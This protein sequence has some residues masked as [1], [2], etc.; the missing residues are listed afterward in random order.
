MSHF[1]NFKRIH[2][3]GFSCKKIVKEKLLYY[4]D[5]LPKSLIELWENEGWCGYAKGFIWVVDPADYVDILNKWLKTSSKPFFAF[6]RTAFGDI[7][8]WDGNEAYYLNVHHDKIKR[9]TDEI[10]I[11][12][13]SVLCDSV[14]LEKLL[15]QGLYQEALPRLGQPNPDECYA[16]VP[17]LVLGGPGTADSLQ[18]VKLRE[19][20]GILAQLMGK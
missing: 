13:N 3:P 16:F 20:L 12:F 14:V 8:L 9:I 2:G 19:H 11:V 18:K 7:F 5:K 1:E 15:L 6:A 10:E 17:A 4:K